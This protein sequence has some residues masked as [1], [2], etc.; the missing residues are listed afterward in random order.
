VS[1]YLSID[2][3]ATG[4]KEGHY[5]IQL[6]LVPVDIS[7]K[8][9]FRELGKE[10]L[11]KCPSFDELLPRLDEWNISHN[12]DLI[13]TANREGLSEAELRKTVHDYLTSDAVKTVFGG[14]RPVLL[15][16]SLSALDIPMLKR[17]LGW[18]NYEKYFHHH[19]LDVTCVARF[20]VDTGVL[21]PGCE[22]SS[23]II[24]YFKIRDQVNHTALSDAID[25]GEIYIKMM[26]PGP[27]ER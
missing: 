23:K 14:N 26:N 13:I 6:A 15:G 20:L 2:T 1:Q 4:L 18:D 27:Q 12:R 22:S 5:M 19:T 3:E 11:V 16:K 8:R 21:P 9:V 17:Y 7:Q 25:M 24:K 10:W